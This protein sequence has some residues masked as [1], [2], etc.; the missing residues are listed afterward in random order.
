MANDIEPANEWKAEIE[1]GL[2]LHREALGAARTSLVTCAQLGFLLRRI[3]LRIPKGNFGTWVEGNYHLSRRTAQYYMQIADRVFEIA[4][5]QVRKKVI[6]SIQCE[7]SSHT[8][9]KTLLGSVRDDIAAVIGDG[10]REELLRVPKHLPPSKQCELSSHP[11]PPETPP[12]APA[13]PDA[14]ADGEGPTEDAPASD[15]TAQEPPELGPIYHQQ[16]KCTWKFER[17]DD[18]WCQWISRKMEFYRL[19]R[20]I[21]AIRQEIKQWV[22]RPCDSCKGAGEVKGDKCTRCEG[23]GKHAQAIA[24]HVPFQSIMAALK[25]AVSNFNAAAPYGPCP[26]CYLQRDKRCKPCGGMGWAPKQI[27]RCAPKELRAAVEFKGKRT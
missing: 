6:H 26:Y 2:R 19:S 10:T 22:M 11:K 1:E 27:Y 4:S 7:L 24:R 25:D 21:T 12:G 17:D 16:D 9:L 23:T 20:Q 5:P 8:E 15:T 18:V 3:K 13:G 14:P